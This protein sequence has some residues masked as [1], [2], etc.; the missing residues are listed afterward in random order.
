M[1]T[2]IF[3]RSMALFLAF[4]LCFTTFIGSAVTPAFAS[5]AQSEVC[6]ISFP[7]EGD[8]NYNATW[9]HGDL[10][11]MGGWHDKAT[12]FLSVHAVGSFTGEIS[13]CIEPGVNVLIGDKLTQRDETY[14]DN[15]PSNLNPTISPDDIK[16]LIGRIMQYGYTGA[17]S[18]DWRSQNDGAPLLAWATATQLLI[19]ETVV[20]ERD[21]EFNKVAPTAGKDPILS[22]IDTGNPLYT[23]IMN[24]Y[25]SIEYNVQ[26]HIKLPS[27]FARS[28]GRAPEVELTW[29]GTQYSTTLTDTNNVLSLYTF[30]ANAPRV[31]CSVNGNQLTITS[32]TTTDGPVTITASKNNSVRK[33]IITWTDGHIG[34]DGTV[35]DLV[36][37][38]QSVSDPIQGYLNVKISLG[39]MKIVKTSEDGNVAGIPFTI[40]GNGVNKTVYTTGI[41]EIQV[42]N[43]APSTYT[44]TE[45]TF[46]QYAPQESRR[47]TVVSGQTATVTFNNTLRRGDLVVTKTAED[48]LVEGTKFHLYGTSLSGVA[49]DEYAVADSTGRAYFRDVLI[50]TG[51]TLEEVDVAARY[52]VPDSQSAAIEWGT[53]TQKSFLA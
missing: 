15:Y 47:V 35:Q 19:W 10:N 17:V 18:V 29:D 39:S 13:Y 14:W 22:E 34:P 20:G 42:D 40:T 31:H 21:A 27:F 4:L 11:F 44:V 5:A 43:L 37:Y 38:T 25:A 32:A 2:S 49:V 26:N 53:V 8:A 33:G 46:D 48:G 16:L 36:T 52:V 6:V 24:Y 28:T 1:K 3:K 51:Y 12:R 7:R 50:G 41:G 30:T 9:G 23:M 45:Q